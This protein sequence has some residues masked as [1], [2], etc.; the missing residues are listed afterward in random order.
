MPAIEVKMESR[1]R[2][3]APTPPQFHN[4]YFCLDRDSC[5]YRKAVQSG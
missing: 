2:W 5:E 4:Y 1:R 3:D